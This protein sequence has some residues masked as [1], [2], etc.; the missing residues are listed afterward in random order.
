MSSNLNYT[1][2]IINIVSAY[3]NVFRLKYYNTL[4][5]LQQLFAILNALFGCISTY[6]VSYFVSAMF[7]STALHQIFAPELSEEELKELLPGVNSKEKSKEPLIDGEIINE[8]E[9][10]V[11]EK[12]TR[13]DIG[14]LND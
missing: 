4:G 1:I 3:F 10:N 8:E 13:N 14:N 5:L 7:L 9:E 2:K 12:E 11:E 6:R